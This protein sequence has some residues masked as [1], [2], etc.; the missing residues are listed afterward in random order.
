MAQ[1]FTDDVQAAVSWLRASSQSS[2]IAMLTFS[3][4]TFPA[5]HMLNRDV[6]A[7]NAVVSDSGPCL[8]VETLCRNFLEAGR[9]RLPG[10]LL[11]PHVFDAF[12]HAY[13]F[14][15]TRMLDVDWPPEPGQFATPVLFIANEC[16]DIM[17]AA[18]VHAFATAWQH[19]ELW[20]VP[21]AA[22]LAAYKSDPARYSERVLSFLGR[23]FANRVSRAP[24]C[25]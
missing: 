16:D 19:G 21:G 23:A 4:S 5:L 13:A 9:P 25:A 14:A 11:R 12:A 10:W 24:S 6:D 22:H 3:F 7:V 1:R 2:D 8:D 20:H 18:D 15:V 17:P